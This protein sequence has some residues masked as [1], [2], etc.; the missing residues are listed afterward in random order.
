VFAD[1]RCIIPVQRLKYLLPGENNNNNTMATIDGHSS[2]LSATT[3]S[4]RTV[5]AVKLINTDFVVE[6]H[7]TVSTDDSDRNQLQVYLQSVKAALHTITE[8]RDD[9]DLVSKRMAAQAL[10]HI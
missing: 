3:R 7:A 9:R 1:Q 5:F 4:T 2:D 8:N 6:Y 10:S